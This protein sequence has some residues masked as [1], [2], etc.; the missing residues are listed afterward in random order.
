[1]GV[2]A[3]SEEQLSLGSLMPHTVT[4][5]LTAQGPWSGDDIAG[6]LS[7]GLLRGS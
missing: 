4:Y 2:I 3:A 5:V 7:R 1:M 6:L